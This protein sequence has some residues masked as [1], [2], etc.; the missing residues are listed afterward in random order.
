MYD[1]DCKTRGCALRHPSRV[2]SRVALAVV[3]GL[4]NDHERAEENAGAAV[5]AALDN[6]PVGPASEDFMIWNCSTYV[7][8]AVRNSNKDIVWRLLCIVIGWSFC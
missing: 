1:G 2:H 3:R 8:M 4:N 6:A 5:L 7:N